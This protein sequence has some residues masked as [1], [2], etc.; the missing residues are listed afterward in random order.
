[1]YLPQDELDRFG[2]QEDDI[3]AGR[4]TPEWRELMAF[5][6]ARARARNE[7]RFGPKAPAK[8]PA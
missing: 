5:Q 4:A 8:A 1:M 7:V 6:A 2:V 3:A